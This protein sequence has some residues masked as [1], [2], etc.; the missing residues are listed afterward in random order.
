MGTRERD[1]WREGGKGREVRERSRGKMKGRKKGVER[2][3]GEV[4][5][6]R[7]RGI[8]KKKLKDRNCHRNK[9]ILTK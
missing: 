4:W 2:G 5:R 8:G 7:E 6:E 9:K 1:G 3:R